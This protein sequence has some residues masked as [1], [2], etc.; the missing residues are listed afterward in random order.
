M[1]Q[2]KDNVD[3]WC[4]LSGSESDDSDWSI[5]WLEPLGSDLESNDNDY[6]DDSSQWQI[7]DPESVGA[8]FFVL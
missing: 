6:E 7:Q 8:N 1:R 3:D 4:F 5:V 2:D